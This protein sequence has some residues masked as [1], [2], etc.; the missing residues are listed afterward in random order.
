MPTQHRQRRKSAYRPAWRFPPIVEYEIRKWVLSPCLHVCAGRSNLGDVKL[1][2]NERADVKA[3]MS[4]LPFKNSQFASVVWDPPYAMDR[5]RTIP[6]LVQ[7]NDVLQAGG[8]LI[9]LHYFDPCVFLQRTMRLLYK[10]YYEPK[11]LGGVRVL[12]V[13]EKLPSRRLPP[14]RRDRLID[15]TARFWEPEPLQIEA[16]T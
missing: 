6:I 12:A 5:V 9:T 15:V 1:D 14:R 2:L 16:T 4:H 8:R 3:T 7:M 10:A 11:S 13:M